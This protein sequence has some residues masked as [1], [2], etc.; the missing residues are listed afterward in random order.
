MYS[1]TEEQADWY[2]CEGGGDAYDFDVVE[3]ADEWDD[4]GKYQYSNV[5]LRHKKT[6]K[7]Y[8][9]EVQ[10]SGSYFSDYFYS[11][12]DIDDLQEVHQVEVTTTALVWAPVE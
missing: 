5:I 4:Q 6:K 2:R 8:T 11:Y 12:C 10:R 3:D 1:L 7:F 9:F